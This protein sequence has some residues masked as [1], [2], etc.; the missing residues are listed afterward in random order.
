MDFLI[1]ETDKEI[2]ETDAIH[3]VTYPGLNIYEMT[4]AQKEAVKEARELMEDQKTES[5]KNYLS[6]INS[7][8]E[9]DDYENNNNNKSDDNN[10]NNN[11]SDDNNNNN[12]QEYESIK[13]D[14]EEVLPKEVINPPVKVY[15]QSYNSNSNSNSTS[16]VERSNHDLILSPTTSSS[17]RKD[18]IPIRRSS[19]ETFVTPNILSYVHHDTVLEDLQN[20]VLSLRKQVATSVNMQMFLNRLE[21]KEDVSVQ[22]DYVRNYAK[23]KFNIII[24]HDDFSSMTQDRVI[25]M[26]NKTR[27]LEKSDKFEVIYKTAFDFCISNLETILNTYVFSIT[28]LNDYLIYDDISTELIDVKRQFEKSIVGKYVDNTSPYIR[29]ISYIGIQILRAKF[30]Y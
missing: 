22:M 25:A 30:K 9:D 21:G 13:N 11:K 19:I 29:I 3:D 24:T 10:S 20:E 12:L 4:S 2:I 18:T 5:I 16:F 7:E 17:E 27:E 28:G 26:Y 8:D 23:K 14:E 6:P 15:N 1:T